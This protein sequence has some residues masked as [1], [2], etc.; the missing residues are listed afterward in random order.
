M[1]KRV[2]VT[3]FSMKMIRTYFYINCN[4]KTSFVKNILAYCGYSPTTPFFFLFSEHKH[5]DNAKLIR[6]ARTLDVEWGKFAGKHG[7]GDK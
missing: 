4:K 7:Y 5:Y 1:K 6:T 2:I 3:H